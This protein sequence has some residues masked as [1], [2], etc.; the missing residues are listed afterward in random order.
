MGVW[1]ETISR[2]CTVV[3]SKSHP[4]WVCGLKLFGIYRD[5]GKP[6]HTLYGCVD[7]NSLILA[8][9]S[10]EV[11]HPVWVCGLKLW[12]VLEKQPVRRSH[13]VWVCGLKPAKNAKPIRFSSHT[14]YGCVDWNNTWVLKYF[15]SWG[16]TLY[17]CVDWNRSRI[18]HRQIADVTPCMGVWIETD[19]LVCKM[20]ALNSHTLYGCVDWNIQLTG[21]SNYSKVTPCMG[22][23]I[24]TLKADFGR[25]PRMSHPVWVCGLKHSVDWAKQLLE[26]HTLYGCVD[27]NWAETSAKAVRGVTPC[28]G[29]WIETQRMTTAIGVQTVTPCMGVWI[30]TNLFLHHWNLLQSH[31]VWVC[32]LKL[33]EWC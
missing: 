16:H 27:W 5:S 20:C 26:S 28:M 30:E 21:R 18:K 3:K 12:Y 25:L 13:P 17:G 23:W 10:P 19:P 4:V 29:V 24:E 2:C 32:G 6:C 8:T 14:L 11:S 31:P 9:W 33:E 22:V 7:W 1:I 15:Q